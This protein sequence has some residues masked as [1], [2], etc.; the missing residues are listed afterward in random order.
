MICDSPKVYKKI[1]LKEID[2]FLYVLIYRGYADDW[3]LNSFIFLHLYKYK[4]EAEIYLVK[5]RER[6]APGIYIQ[7]K[8]NQEFAEKEELLIKKIKDKQLRYKIL[9]RVPGEKIY[10]IDMKR[11][12]ELIKEMIEFIWDKILKWK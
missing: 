3:L 9:K 1:D 2:K 4:F 10:F 11:D 5:Y 12:Y 6:G 7:T 8:I